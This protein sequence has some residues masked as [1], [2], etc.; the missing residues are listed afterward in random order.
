MIEIY[1]N[2]ERHKLTANIALVEILALKQVAEQSVAVVVN[3][4][5]IPRSEWP[6][7]QCQ[8]GDQVEFF[9]AVAGG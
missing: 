7:Y 4:V 1:I 2:G 9:S 5:I 6:H 8:I 3:Q